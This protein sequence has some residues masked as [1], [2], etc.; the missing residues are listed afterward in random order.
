VRSRSMRIAAPLAVGA[1]VLTACGSNKSEST[2]AAGSASP[3]AD[4]GNKTVVIGLSAPLSGKLSSLGLGMKNS[5]DLAVKQANQKQT[6]KGWTIKW[7][8]EDDQGQANIGQQVASKLTS[9]K[10]VA[11]VVG[12]L[13]SSVSIQEQP[14][15]S[16]A[17]IV[18][19]SPAN[20]TVDLT[21]GPNWASG[22]KKRPFASYFRVATT[23]EVQGSFAADYA[24]Q[25]LGKKKAAVV[26]DKKA[27]GAGLATVFKRQFAKDGGQVVADETVGENDQD[28]SGVVSKLKNT[29]PDMVF[30]GGEYPAASLFTSQMKQAGLNVPLMGG[31]GIY[32]PTYINVAKQAA[33]GDFCTSVGAPTESLDSAKQF[34]TDYRAA[35]YPEPFGAYGANTYDATNVVIAALA[36]VL[37]S[38]TAVD[39][40]T[41]KDIVKEVQ[42]GTI[43]GATGKVSFDQYGDTTNKTLTVYKVNGGQWKAEKT[44]TFQG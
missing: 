34:V 3:G 31:D 2:G 37:P 14:V 22:D 25:T 44:G 9:T 32:D 43:T 41:R 12:A 7:Q 26:N 1:I 42:D 39:D 33:E 38:K 18:Q 17:S 15:F 28:F 5:G 23:D 19:I 30:Y 6:V 13:N 24:A 36:K 21:Q 40:S 20:T 27:Y 4:G 10:D 35:S 16:G 11:G 29:N 8:P